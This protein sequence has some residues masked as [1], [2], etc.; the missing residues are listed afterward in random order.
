MGLSKVPSL[1]LLPLVHTLH[2]ELFDDIHI[3]LLGWQVVLWLL[4]LIDI[5][6]DV[7]G[8]LLHEALFLIIIAV[9]VD[10]TRRFLQTLSSDFSMDT[11][12][13]LLWAFLALLYIDF[14]LRQILLH[15]DIVSVS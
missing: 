15:E 8:H 13:R 6:S 9:E 14:W 7:F 11:N 1:L 3:D 10:Y 5:L 2:L 12:L 4:T